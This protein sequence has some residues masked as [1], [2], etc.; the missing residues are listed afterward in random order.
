LSISS[1]MISRYKVFRNSEGAAPA[2]VN[3]ELSMLTKALNLA[4]KE[5]E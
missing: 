5:W 1:K 3:R 4:V 2:S